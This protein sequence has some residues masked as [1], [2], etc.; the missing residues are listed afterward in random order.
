MEDY[1]AGPKE[2]K[3]KIQNENGDFGSYRANGRATLMS[4]AENDA[5]SPKIAS[6]KQLDT[7]TIFKKVHNMNFIEEAISIRKSV[8]SL[9]CKGGHWTPP[10][11]IT[12]A[13]I[14]PTLAT[15]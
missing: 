12:R 14:C 10:S 15:T 2:N 1:I 7:G 3:R 5:D 11:N 4:L 13:E 8:K 6:S 9:K